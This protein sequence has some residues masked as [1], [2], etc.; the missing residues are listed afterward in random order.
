MLCTIHHNRKCFSCFFF[1][2]FYGEMRTSGFDPIFHFSLV[3]LHCLL[4]SRLKI[5]Y[6]K[7]IVSFHITF[8]EFLYFRSLNIFVVQE[9]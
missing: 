3:T 4:F 5:E 8:R 2:D 7:G 6:D 1:K 9:F